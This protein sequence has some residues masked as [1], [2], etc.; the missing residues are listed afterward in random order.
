MLDPGPELDTVDRG[1]TKR[2][3]DPVMNTPLRAGRSK[4]ADSYIHTFVATHLR[5]GLTAAD[6]QTES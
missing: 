1:R 5:P 2:L 3:A 6:A 4:F